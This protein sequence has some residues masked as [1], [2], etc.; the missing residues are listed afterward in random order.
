MGIRLGLVRGVFLEFGKS[1][2][3][4]WIWS[5]E[6]IRN[7]FVMQV[8]GGF[9]GEYQ[10]RHDAIWPELAAALRA[11]GVS[12]YSIFLDERTGAFLRCRS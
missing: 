4:G 9:E 1:S 7:G 2:W 3:H 12:D 8:K 5:V 11:A 6:M 10:R